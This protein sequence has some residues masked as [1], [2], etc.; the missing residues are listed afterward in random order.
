M[1]SLS[2][3]RK[4]IL[5]YQKIEKFS[6]MLHCAMEWDSASFLIWKGRSSGARKLPRTAI[7]KRSEHSP[8]VTKG[9]GPDL[10][11]TRAR[12]FIGTYWPPKQ[13]TEI[14]SIISM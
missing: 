1:I 3:M 5:P 12:H 6:S 7:W 13:V 10:E 14:P 2:M 4:G 8:H 9:A 11:K